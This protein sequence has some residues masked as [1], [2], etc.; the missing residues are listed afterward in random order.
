[1]END[2]RKIQNE[3]NELKLQITQKNLNKNT[4]NNKEQNKEINLSQALLEYGENDS[5]EEKEEDYKQKYLDM[6]EEM[7]MY[8]NIVNPL[9]EDKEGGNEDDENMEEKYKI[10]WNEDMDKILIDYYFEK[11]N[12]DR[13]N[14]DDVVKDLIND[15]LKEF[16]IDFKKNDIRHRLHKLKVKKGKKRAMKK[17]NKIHHISN[18]MDVDS[19]NSKDKNKIK[20]KNKKN[21]ENKNKY[22]N[23]YISNYIY[24]L[25]DKSKENEYKTKLDN[26]FTF[27]KDQLTSYKK[28]IDILGDTN[29][30]NNNI[31]CELIPTSVD[32]MSILK[33]EDLKNLLFTVGFYYNDDTE[34]LTL[35]SDKI[36]DIDLLVENIDLYKNII[37]ENVD[38]MN[39]LGI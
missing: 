5:F 12:E 30:D 22:S 13:S 1:M 21:K 28:K 23:D 6:K 20:N 38:K 34:Y 9:T 25:S 26:C 10:K 8:K 39:L 15:K 24:K 3:Y 31:K 14:I 11:I 16:N 37:E 17:F 32:D 18:S 35:K 7:E 2:L 4:K 33:D 36:S 29:N 19:D 27:V